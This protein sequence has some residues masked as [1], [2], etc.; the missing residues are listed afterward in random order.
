MSTLMKLVI[1]GIAVGI[2][3]LIVRYAQTTPFASA[4]LVSTT[5]TLIVGILFFF[6]GE[7][8][9]AVKE[10]SWNMASGILGAIG[11]TLYIALS[12]DK[13]IPSSTSLVV[14]NAIALATII[15]GGV[16]FFGEALPPLKMLAL[17]M[18]TASFTMLLFL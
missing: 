16:W 17:A 8:M 10:I 3:P 5:T 18:M 11:F 9:P 7:T 12:A 2:Y 4:F 14:I 1:A 15:V 6:S 13:A